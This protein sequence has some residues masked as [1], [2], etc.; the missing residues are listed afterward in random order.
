MLSEFANYIEKRPSNPSHNRGESGVFSPTSM[1]TDTCC[2]IS[3][4]LANSHGRGE[5]SH[6]VGEFLIRVAN[7]PGLSLSHSVC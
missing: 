5:N 6:L 4:Y 2:P 3:R 1:R 7:E